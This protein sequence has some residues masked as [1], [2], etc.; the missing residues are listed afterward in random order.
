M[1]MEGCEPVRVKGGGD[2]LGSGWVRVLN[3]V[4]EGVRDRRLF[5]RVGWMSLAGPARGDEGM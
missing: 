5:L 3:L 1:R 4:R 2:R